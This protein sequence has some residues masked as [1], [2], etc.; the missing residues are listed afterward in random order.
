MQ[1]LTPK[2]IVE[3]LDKYIVGQGDATRAEPRKKRQRA[4]DK[5]LEQ[6]RTGELEARPIELQV[7]QRTTAIGILGSA[8]M[9]MDVELESM[10][11]KMLPAKRETRRATVRDA[12]RILFA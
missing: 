1:H 6:L 5:H 11:E 4:R 7:E 3:Q 8:G 10:F 12:R 9:Q 2:Q